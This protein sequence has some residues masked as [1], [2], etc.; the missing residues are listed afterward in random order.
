MIPVTYHD[1][2]NKGR[3]VMRRT[4]TEEQISFLNELPGKYG[5]M[6]TKYAYRFFGYRPH[7]L[8]AAQDAVQDTYVK[9]VRHVETLM[10]HE[11]IAGWLITSLRHNLLTASRKLKTKK[12]EPMAD[13]Q[14]A[15]A[16]SVQAM[17]DALERWEQ[18]YQFSELL[19]AVASLLTDDEQNTFQDY[20]L[21]GYSTLET[22]Q[23]EGV[24]SDT[25]RG[26]ISRIRKKLKKHFGSMCLF[27]LLL[28]YI[29]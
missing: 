8:P 1:V 4:L 26:R 20:F 14:N 12:E 10:N 7:L 24:S 29:N 22:A 13:V 25:V 23:M 16:V 3:H 27:I 15:S 11:N 6:L 5:D 28:H 19:D 9:A 21:S 2:R 18:Q 17:I